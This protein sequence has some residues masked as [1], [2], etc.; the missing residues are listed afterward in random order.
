MPVTE[1]DVAAD[2]DSGAARRIAHPALVL[3]IIAGAQLMVVLDATI[4]NIAL[5][6]MGDYFHKSQTDMTW[7]LNAYTLA[8]GGLLLLG[9]RA[10]DILGRRRMFIVGLAL[11]TLGSFAGGI[12]NSFGLLLAGRV[13][14]GVGGAIASPT[15][16]SLITVSFAEGRERNRA[17]G[18]YAAVSGA[19][20]AIGLLLGGVLTEYLDWRWVLFVNVPIGVVLMVGAFLYL[21]EGE[22][23]KGKFDFLGALVSVAGMVTLVYA[24]IHVAN[25]QDWTSPSTILLFTGAIV[26]L[27]A[28][29]LLEAFV[30]EEPMM[31]M[32]IFEDRSRS[33]AYLVMLIA[34]AGLF[35]MFFFLTFFVQ[36]VMH[37]S[38]LK[39]GLAF[40][41]VAFV[42]GIVSQI[43]AQLL[44]KI[45]PK[46][47]IT[48]GTVLLTGALLWLST[49]TAD[50]TYWGKIFPGEMVL[51]VGMGFIFVPITTVAVSKVKDTDAGLASAL[52]N[53]G[54][55]VGGS[56]GLSVLA[57]VAATAARN[58]ASSKVADLAA[59]VKSGQLP[60]STLQHFGEVSAAQ[61]GHQA[62]TAALRD[63][64][65]AQAVA[66]VQ[67]HASSMGFL[68]ATI[69]AAVAV[70]V[71]LVFI[72]VK[73]TEL[74]TPEAAT[75]GAAA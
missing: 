69:F 49:V 16:L 59:Q 72:N 63:S 27:A 41:P 37:F 31:P 57:T 18:V 71:S 25:T 26:L 61:T 70:V 54:Q 34:G 13:V 74:P 65:A 2:T 51:A 62:S 38:A 5:P 40:V 64:A 3:L 33:G 10:G 6:S 73:K 53:V 9:G 4:V 23:L 50:S 19:G 11:F 12:A 21:H 36:Q 55:Q 24:F 43:V 14:Q 29:V 44:P 52:L 46:V 56:I 75:A 30:I 67:A 60:P 39:A 68:A 47:L 15:A 58:A 66:E 28:F 45:G 22:R 1:I 7:A 42:I 17:V 8:F 20:A 35:G 48:T 32:R